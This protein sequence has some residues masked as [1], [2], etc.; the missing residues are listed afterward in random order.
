M[1][2]F[3][4]VPPAPF[5]MT[6]LWTNPSPT[7]GM[8]AGTTSNITGLSGYDL[9]MVLYKFDKDTAQYLSQFGLQGDTMYLPL[10]GSTTNRAGSRTITINNDNSFTVSTGGYNGSSSSN[11]EIPY[12]IYGIKFGG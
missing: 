11:H 1:K 3:N 9:Y 12:K 2:G 4:Y 7:S 10:T 6:L 5:T 8:S